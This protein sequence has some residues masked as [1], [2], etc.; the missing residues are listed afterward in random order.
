MGSKRQRRIGTRKGKQQG[1]MNR[2]LRLLKLRFETL[3]KKLV[4]KI[5]QQSTNQLIELG[6]L[7]FSSVLELK[8]WLFKT[9][10]AKE[11]VDTSIEQLKDENG[12]HKLNDDFFAG[13]AIKSV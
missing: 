6:T 10:P 9:S 2:T 4:K 8:K 7:S 5:E 13:L 11:E 12:E 1:T 3:D